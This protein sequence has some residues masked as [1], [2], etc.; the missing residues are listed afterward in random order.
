MLPYIQQ[1]NHIIGIGNNIVKKIF[2]Q[3]STSIQDPTV[4]IPDGLETLQISVKS[5]TYK[6]KITGFAT[7]LQ[8]NIEL[9]K[10]FNLYLQQL[11][12]ATQPGQLKT[13]IQGINSFLSNNDNCRD[14]TKFVNA[15]GPTR[16]DNATCFA[17]GV[18]EG[19]GFLCVNDGKTTDPS[20]GTSLSHIS[21]HVNIKNV[22]RMDLH[23][24]DRFGTHHPDSK[25]MH[26]WELSIKE[27]GTRD[28]QLTAEQNSIYN[29][30]NP[31]N[32]N[33][34]MNKFEKI[35]RDNGLLLLNTCKNIVNQAGG[36]WQSGKQIGKKPW[37]EK[38]KTEP[39]KLKTEP[40]TETEPGPETKVYE[41][42][43]TAYIVSPAEFFELVFKNRKHPVFMP[44]H[45]DEELKIIIPVAK[46]DGAGQN[47]STK[48]K[49]VPIV[50]GFMIT[51][52]CTLL[53]I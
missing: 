18:Y 15:L 17:A 9:Y 36:R 3:F 52:M 53:N 14:M 19:K 38:L 2:D 46:I 45:I 13:D 6:T 26:K 35:A 16:F 20:P 37:P 48:S 41:T 34:Q 47:R 28:Y 33:A 42:L 51:I 7:Y 5:Y 43:M 12:Q 11:D 25:D 31:N 24:T 22:N 39:Q 32:R 4:L 44:L 50:I 1:T 10:Q 49:L 27:T 40:E 8:A 30:H 23:F 21:I 29:N